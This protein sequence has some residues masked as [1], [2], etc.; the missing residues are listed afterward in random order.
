MHRSASV[1]GDNYTRQFAN[2]QDEYSQLV[3]GRNVHELMGV[4]KILMKLT[5]WRMPGR[6]ENM[7][8]CECVRQF[9]S[10]GMSVTGMHDM[11]DR[12]TKRRCA[13]M[14]YR[15]CQPVGHVPQKTLRGV[16][17]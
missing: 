3:K 14:Q 7:W 5:A 1:Q 12:T 8:M 2:R 15:H 6:N 11:G 4:K 16:C 10:D 9:A 13:A 17:E